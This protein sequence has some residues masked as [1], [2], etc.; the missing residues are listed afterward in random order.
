MHYTETDPDKKFTPAPWVYAIDGDS[1]VHH[2]G[3]FV[4]KQPSVKTDCTK[5]QWIKNANLIALA[6]ELYDFIEAHLELLPDDIED[7]AQ[8]LLARARG[9]RIR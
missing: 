4:C 3:R 2:G 8:T 1:V 9:Y 6:P 7:S 5:E